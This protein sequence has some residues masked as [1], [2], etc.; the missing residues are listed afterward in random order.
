MIDVTHDGDDRGTRTQIFFSVLF[1]AFG[2]ISSVVGFLDRLESVFTGDEFDLIAVGRALITDPN[3]PQK[4]RAGDYES[5]LSFES[6]AL[7]QLV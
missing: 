1:L 2:K 5:M 6:S 7:A 3:W 4:V